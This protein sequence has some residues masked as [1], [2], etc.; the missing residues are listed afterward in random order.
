MCALMPRRR[1][2]ST[3]GGHQRVAS[4][5]SAQARLVGRP[6][7]CASYASR[8]RFANATSIYTSS[9]RTAREF[10][11]RVPPAMVGVNIGVAAPMS[12]FTFGGSKGS[13]FGDLKAHG[14][15]AISFFTDNKTA[16]TRWW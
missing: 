10:V 9:G 4:N 5:A 2:C 1:C 14:R 16:I 3:S 7:R 13:M 12:F 8:Y 11:R 6:A 15:D